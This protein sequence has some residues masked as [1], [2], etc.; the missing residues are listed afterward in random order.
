VALN[1]TFRATATVPVAIAKYAQDYEIRYTQMAASA[2]LSL[3]PAL[4]LLGQRHIVKGLTAGA[5]K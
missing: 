5:L 3:L 2:A 4:A 1:L